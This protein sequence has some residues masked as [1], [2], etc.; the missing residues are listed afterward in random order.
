MSDDI[1][2]ALQQ[3]LK[4][5][6]QHPDHWLLAGQ[7]R[8]LYTLMEGSRTIPIQGHIRAWLELFSVQH[9]LP[10]WQPAPSRPES[11]TEMLLLMTKLTERVL[12]DRIEELPRAELAIDWP[13][14]A[15]MMTREPDVISVDEI[16]SLNEEINALTSETSDSQYFH[17]W[18][19][20]SAA[21]AALEYAF[22]IDNFVQEYRYVPDSTTMIT[23]AYGDAANYAAITY[24]GG[25]WQAEIPEDFVWDY[26]WVPEG[27]WNRDLDEVRA[28]RQEF[29][30]WWLLDALPRAREEAQ[31]YR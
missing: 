4:A 31:R 14:A 29:W 15:S 13:N 8:T 10:L 18:C 1:E 26:P 30:E 3:M 19:V 16:V 22:G 21:L 23:S 27:Y 2:Q 7:R 25:I 12:R 5:V 11:E 17:T 28:R 20:Y 6:H 24:A 9:V